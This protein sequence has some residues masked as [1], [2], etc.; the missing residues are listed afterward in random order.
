[1]V[2]ATCG[3]ARRGGELVD[4]VLRTMEDIKA[5]S[6]RAVEIISLI[7]GI[8]F[9][10]NILALNAAVEAA[11]AGEAGRGFS[12]VAGEVRSLAQRAADAARDIKA[13]IGETVNLVEAG[14]RIVTDA[15]GGMREI[16]TS[17]EHAES[18]MAKISSASETQS[19]G[20]GQINVAISEMDVITQ[21]N[22]ALVEQTSAAAE[23]L[24]QQATALRSALA[25]FEVE[26]A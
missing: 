17:A 18:F 16:V 5:S 25:G 10:T 24:K 20:I 1:M 12:V 8:S 22:A 21:Q 7:D 13:L 19:T 23:N 9:Q 15:G 4:G 3:S 6:Q 14:G 11:R 26:Q 2:A